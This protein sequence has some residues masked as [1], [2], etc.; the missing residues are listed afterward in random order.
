MVTG[1]TYKNERVKVSKRC[2][3]RSSDD[4]IILSINVDGIEITD[5][6]TM[7]EFRKNFKKSLDKVRGNG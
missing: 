1:K 6:I 3:A 5:V 7:E 4:K 2:V